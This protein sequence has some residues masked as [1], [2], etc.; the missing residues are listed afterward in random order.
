[1]KKLN[2]LLLALSVAATCTLSAQTQTPASAPKVLQ[3]TREYTKPYKGGSDHEKAESAFVEAFRKANLP[4]HY[5][6]LTSMSGKDR[7]IFMT[8]FDSFDAWNKYYESVSQ[9]AALTAE[10]DRAGMADAE[11]LESSDSGVFYRNDEMSL[12]TWTDLSPLR[13][14]EI[15][16]Y[17]VKPGHEG[18]WEEAVK[19]VKATY[20]K[21]DIGAH[22]GMFHQDYGGPEGRYLVLQGH[23]TMA[24]LDAARADKKFEAALGELG[25]KRLDQLVG[26]C[27]ETSQHELFAVN[28]RMSY[29]DDA[30]INAAPDFWKPKPAA[31]PAAKAGEKKAK[32]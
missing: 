25:G 14:L 16:S 17:Q 6:T 19:L 22:W 12:N 32:K 11:L 4:V 3:I 1:M 24:E 18:E 10:L 30:W 23:K 5:I 15:S 9:N 20:E 13:F 7:T 26:T 21:A 31:E 29:V 8:F 2:L 28:P 27:V